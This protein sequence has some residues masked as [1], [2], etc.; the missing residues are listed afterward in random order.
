MHFCIRP[1]DCVIMTQSSSHP[2]RAKI[3]HRQYIQDLGWLFHDQSLSFFEQRLELLEVGILVCNQVPFILKREMN[4]WF[5]RC[6]LKKSR[7]QH[8]GLRIEWTRA[9]TQFLWHVL[10]DF[11]IVWDL[12]IEVLYPGPVKL[13][14][15]TTMQFPATSLT[16]NVFIPLLRTRCWVLI[17]VS[18]QFP[19]DSRDRFRNSAPDSLEHQ[20][21]SWCSTNEEGNTI[22]H[23]WNFLC[24]FWCQHICFRFWGPSWFCQ[25]TNLTRLCAFWTRVSSLDLVLWWSSWSLP[26]CLQKCT[27]A[28]HIEKKF[29]CGHVI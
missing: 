3:F 11:L 29:F 17:F 2:K 16:G 19:G 15:N 22:H 5:H 4:C 10:E 8:V 25:T 23:A 18:R 27:T 9:E 1:L 24:W 20:R 13:I 7:D 14:F 6:R 12:H 21:N 26:R 28:L